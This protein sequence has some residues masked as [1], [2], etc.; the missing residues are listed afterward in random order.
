MAH[1]LEFANGRYSFAFT[2]DRGEI[3]HKLGQEMAS[4]A[5]AAEWIA[6]AGFNYRVEKVPAIADLSRNEA[7]NH[8]NNPY[9]ESDKRFL[10]RTDTGAVLGFASDG[11]QVVQPADV[12][13]WFDRYI[14]VDPRF[15]ISAA[16]V[17]HG[18]ERLWATARFNGDVT[19]AGDAH[20]AYLLM[21]TSFDQ[22]APTTNQATM[23]R[24]VCSNTL[25][26]A[27]SDK[28]AAIK[29]RHSTVFQ[30][31]RVAKELAQIAQS[32]AAYKQLGDA[33]AQVNMSYDSVRQFFR[34]V[35]EIPLESKKDDVSTRKLNQYADLSHAYTVTKQERNSNADDV[36][37]ALQ[38]VTRY[39]D[40][41]RSV[42]GAADPIIGRF[43]S[44]VFGSGD[45]LKGKAMALLL[46]L[47]KDKVP[48][49]V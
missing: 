46:P 11:Y 20:R 8:L 34:N 45:D 22:T 27:H 33:M 3:W 5:P 1:E 7:F 10:V 4:D 23:T 19:V 26:M 9:V 29:T 16:G 44:G 25:R 49:L 17:L 28:R 13:D 39:V 37:S 15:H 35:L 43:D 42:K 21:S 18:G 12:W 32:F 48:A 2:G 47:V 38:A 24:A 6:A 36:W 41:D 31:D 30:G 40:H 14:T